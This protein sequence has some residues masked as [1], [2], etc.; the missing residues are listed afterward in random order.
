MFRTFR[1]SDVLARDLRVMDATAI[2]L[3]RENKIPVRVFNLGRKG[4][5]RDAVCGKSIGTIVEE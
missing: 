4:N 1:Y 2:S 5:I 3:C